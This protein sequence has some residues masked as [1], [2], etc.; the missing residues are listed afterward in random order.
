MR[1]RGNGM[2]EC[3]KTIAIS[4]IICDCFDMAV[5]FVNSKF[6]ALEH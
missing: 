2:S 5:D 4:A 3:I 1:V 6:L